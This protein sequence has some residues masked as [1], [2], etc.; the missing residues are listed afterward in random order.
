MFLTCICHTS[1]QSIK[2][3]S[4]LRTRAHVQFHWLPVGCVAE[5][6]LAGAHVDA[7]K[8]F[9]KSDGINQIVYVAVFLI[10]NSFDSAAIW[11]FK[12]FQG[13]FKNVPF[14][15]ETPLPPQNNQQT[16]VSFSLKTKSEE[17]GNRFSMC[18]TTIYLSPRKN[19]S[20][21][22][23]EFHQKS[24]KWFR[25]IYHLLT[26]EVGTEIPGLQN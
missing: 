3:S 20:K 15:F 22:L 2:F 12:K 8:A 14:L 17:A 7:W 4:K 9:S 13:L 24:S 11:V 5:I 1:K 23:K 6:W 16:N 21:S 25:G 18:F 19:M 10:C 26:E